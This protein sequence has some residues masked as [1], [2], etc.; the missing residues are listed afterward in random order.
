MAPR[1]FLQVGYVAAATPPGR[2]RLRY[3]SMRH[4]VGNPSQVCKRRVELAVLWYRG[5]L[6]ST[7]WHVRA[8]FT[9]SCFYVLHAGPRIF[10]CVFTYCTTLRGFLHMVRASFIH[11]VKPCIS[12]T[13]RR[14][15][16]TVGFS[17]GRNAALSARAGCSR[18]YAYSAPAGRIR[19]YRYPAPLCN[20]RVV[21]LVAP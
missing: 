14:N 8:P 18:E 19:G 21:G 12:C 10:A 13:F 3:F 9:W 5:H 1:P 15:P 7:G 17:S 4:C 11:L 6:R 20:G 2:Q 16:N